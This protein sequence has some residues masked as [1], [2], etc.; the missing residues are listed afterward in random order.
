MTTSEM[1]PLRQVFRIIR[2]VTVRHH[3]CSNQTAR[4]GR[5]ESVHLAVTVHVC[6]CV[7]ACV[8]GS[9][10]YACE[11]VRACFNVCML[12]CVHAYIFAGVCMCVGTR[13]HPVCI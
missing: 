4:T 6:T 9:C 12:E 3:W 7:R 5:Q 2:D 11:Y 8:R 10:M 13:V 1:M